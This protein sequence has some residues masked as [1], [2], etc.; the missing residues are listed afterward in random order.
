M[1]IEGNSLAKPIGRGVLDG[2]G[3]RGDGTL[4]LRRLLELAL[5]VEGF[6][7]QQQL[8]SWTSECVDIEPT[9]FCQNGRSLMTT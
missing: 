1:E 3:S 2:G 4:Q 8:T 9:R 7:E 6:E 5:A